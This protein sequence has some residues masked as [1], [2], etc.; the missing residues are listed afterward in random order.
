[1]RLLCRAP[2]YRTCSGRELAETGTARF[3]SD[4]DPWL[5]TPRQFHTFTIAEGAE[6]HDAPMPQ[7][8]NQVVFDWLDDTLG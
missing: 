2:I 7:T 1:M 3:P 4:Y 5:S 8:R 6:F